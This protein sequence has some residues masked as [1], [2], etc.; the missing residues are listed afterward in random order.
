VTYADLYRPT[1]L[2]KAVFE[3]LTQEYE[4]AK[5]QEARETPSVKILDPPEVPEKKDF[6]PRTL[7]A[8]SSTGIGFFGGVVVLLATK[9]WDEKDPDDLSKAVANEIW[10]DLKEKRSLDSVDPAPLPSQS[11]SQSSIQLE[12]G[13]L[14]FL[15]WNKGTRNGHGYSSFAPGGSTGQDAGSDPSENPDSGEEHGLRG[16]T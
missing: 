3:V 10:V 12:R 9:G 4:L 14:S 7:I 16:T 6:P 1:R 5:V 2:Q 8:V 15:G 11:H 13:I